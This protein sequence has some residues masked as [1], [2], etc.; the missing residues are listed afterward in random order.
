MHSLFS[1]TREPQEAEKLHWASHRWDVRVTEHVDKAEAVDNFFD[2]LLGS[3][4]DRPFTLDLDFLGLPSFDL[5]HIDG[6]FTEAEVGKRSK[7][8]L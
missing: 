6:E 4:V 3:V 5:Q 8:C 1:L 7:T 2:D